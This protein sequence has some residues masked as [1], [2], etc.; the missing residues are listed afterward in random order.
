MPEIQPAFVGQDSVGCGDGIDVNPEMEAMRRTDASSLP[1]S[2]LVLW[3]PERS[4]ANRQ[5]IGKR[6]QANWK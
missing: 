4:E 6:G 1:G 2:N 3:R 5:F